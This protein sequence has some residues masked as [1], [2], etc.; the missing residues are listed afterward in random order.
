MGHSLDELVILKGV[1]VAFEFNAIGE[2][3]A[4]RTNIFMGPEMC[5]TIAEYCSLVTRTFSTLA[6][7]FT[8]ISE[9]NWIP[10]RSWTYSGGDFTVVIGGNGSRGVF[11]ETAEANWGELVSALLE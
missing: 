1:T 11:A 7:A 8:G 5:A 9:Q 3:T 10:L 4:Y 2:C 6:D